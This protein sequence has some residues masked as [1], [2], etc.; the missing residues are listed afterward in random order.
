MESSKNGVSKR[1]VI[2]LVICSILVVVLVVLFFLKFLSDENNKSDK[3][4]DSGSVVMLYDENSSIFFINDMKSVVDDDGRA[5]DN[6]GTFYDFSIKVNIGDSKST[7][8]D[9]A[10]VMNPD[11]STAR[12]S[13]VMI[14]LEREDSGSYVPVL[15][16]T[17]FDLLED[18]SNRG[19]DTGSKKLVGV[20]SKEDTLHNYRLRM[21]LRDGTVITPEVLQ[22]FGV[23]IKLYGE[24]K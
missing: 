21:W 17:I 10:L 5:N 11:F 2:T 19:S 22:S 1:L 14:Y 18:V 15:E 13:D 23:E 6:P 8:Y 12:S 7:S 20:T 16:P 4:L 3:F 24:A 9:L